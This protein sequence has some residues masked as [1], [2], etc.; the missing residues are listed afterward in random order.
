MIVGHA[1]VA[2]GAWARDVQHQLTES[3]AARLEPMSETA[4][5]PGEVVRCTL[6]GRE[7]RLMAPTGTRG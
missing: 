3:P 4:D 1:I 6:Q 2:M 5:C 7:V